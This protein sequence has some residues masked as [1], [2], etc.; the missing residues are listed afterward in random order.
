MKSNH[1][2]L[3][4]SL[5]D[6]HDVLAALIGADRVHYLDIPMH[7][8]IG[9]LLI[10]SGTL[11][12]FERYQIKIG[13]KAAYFSYRT[14]WALPNDVIVFQG[15]GNFGDLYD[16]HQQI[17]HHVIQALPGNRIIILPQTI[18]FRSKD[19]YEECCRAFWQHPD[20]HI[21]VRDRSSYELALPMSRNVYLLPDMAHQ[22]WP[23]RRPRLSESHHLAFMR[24]DDERA[25]AIVTDFD[26]RTDWE[27]LFQR[28]ERRRIQRTC[29][30]LRALHSMRFSLGRI[31]H[32][33]DLWV[34]YAS[35]FV[36]DAIHLFS[37]FD[38]ITTDRLHAHLLACLLEIPNTIWNNSYGKNHTY[39]AAWTGAS[40]IVQ[41][42]PV[43][44][45]QATE[46][47]ETC[48]IGTC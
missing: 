38:V 47:I 28:S 46:A 35:R 36:D 37:G 44:R 22:L 13:V 1:A 45:P 12:F 14:K 18:H 48:C 17:R 27:E 43:N 30:V 24:V 32:E 29:R 11:R 6:K 19:A 3:M 21:C 40:D 8:N 26:L 33:L 9:D 34:R 2:E 25:G 7:R 42:G 31:S 39:V 23:M 15:G 5:A 41:L 4:Q 20:L 10:M 16:G